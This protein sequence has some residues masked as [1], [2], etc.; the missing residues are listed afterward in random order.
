MA[1]ADYCVLGLAI[2]GS[3]K[4]SSMS[5]ILLLLL[6]VNEK[7]SFL[8]NFGTFKIIMRNNNM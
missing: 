3:T 4:D 8:T 1:M 5:R 7:A 6:F 2:S